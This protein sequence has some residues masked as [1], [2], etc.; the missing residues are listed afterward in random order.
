[1]GIL[2]NGFYVLRLYK[3]GVIIFFASAL[4]LGGWGIRIFKV[5]DQRCIIPKLS[6]ALSFG[7]VLLVLLT[8]TIVLAGRI[9][10]P[11]L[12]YCSQLIPVIGLV[13]LADWIRRDKLLKIRLDLIFFCLFF[14]VT[15]LMRLAFLKGI[16]LPP[17]DDSPEHY[18]IVKDLLARGAISNAFYSIDAIASRYY[19]F[20]FHFLAVWISSASNID[21]ADSISLLGQLFL[22][23]LPISVFTL[24]YSTT[25]NNIAG[26]VAMLFSAFAWQMPAFASNWGKY[27]AI[28]GLSLFPAVI[29]LW[30]FYWRIPDKKILTIM[31]LIITTAG[32][33]FVHTRL[34]ICLS[35]VLISFFITRKFFWLAD[36]YY[37]KALL[38]ALLSIAAFFPIRGY[39]MVFYGNGHY[40]ALVLVMLLLPFAFY[41]NPRLSLSIVLFIFGIWVLSQI[42]ISFE[43]YGTALL[44][45]P[46]IEILLCIPISFLSGVGCAGLLKQIQHPSS[47]WIA[48][49]VIL[50]VITFSFLSAD[51]VY[52]DECCNYVTVSDVEAIQW[53]NKNTPP[54]AVIWIAAFKPGRYMIA[55][56]AGAWVSALTGR[57]ANKLNYDF[58]WTSHNSLDKICRPTY[59]DVYIYKGHGLYSFADEKLTDQNWLTP[60]FTS[61]ETKVYKLKAPCI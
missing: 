23:I 28:A 25:Q 46:F 40:L 42:S 7:C 35:L 37:W 29:G 36:L 54:N 6:L 22:V 43:N 9:W 53:L 31:I 15:L 3:E 61:G 55:T 10:Y 39:L 59:G 30:V 12:E 48:I 19:H 38:L 2:L 60:V 27:P 26:F 34:A 1:M 21:A 20:G 47:M 41:L 32:L 58:V 17:Y 18:I 44:D 56:D 8:F 5:D 52:P 13:A 51:S 33:V 14:I 50:C 4:G 49:L 45:Q 24:A 57:N 11:I 16:V